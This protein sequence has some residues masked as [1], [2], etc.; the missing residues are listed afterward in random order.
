MRQLNHYFGQVLEA[1]ALLGCI[2]LFT[3]MLMICGDVV[4]RSTNWGSLPWANEIS[5]YSLYV[6]TFL[7]APLL[8]RMGKHV[9]L[10]MA[11]RVLPPRLGWMMEW[12]VDLVG[13]GVCV[14]MTLASL[15]I[16]LASH[17]SGSIVLKT[18]SFPEWWL[19]MPIPIT[20]F[21]LAVE[22]IFRMYRLAIGPRELRDE[23][24][25]AA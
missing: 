9:R 25:S 6:A 22:F 3:M 20:F 4:L 18:L 10:D 1:V 2:L 16:L 11:L 17:T 5:E 21:L 12:L 13:L 24:I 15:R 14:A 23:A 19:L 8:L 7:A